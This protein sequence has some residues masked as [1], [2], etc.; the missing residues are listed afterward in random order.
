MRSSDAPRLADVAAG[1]GVSLAT[2]SRAMTGGAGVSEQLAA[3]VREVAER[4]GYVPNLHARGLAGGLIASIGLIVHEIGDPYF[5]EIASGVLKSAAAS[6]RSVQIAHAERDPASE[7][8]QVRTLMAQRLGSIIIAGSGYSDAAREAPLDDLLRTYRRRGGRVAVIGRHHLAVDAVL[9]DNLAAG[10]SLGRHLLALGHRRVGL[11][12][13]P[14]DINTVRDRVDGMR[15]V[16]EPA[17]ARIDVVSEVFAR[18]GGVAG[19]ERLLAESPDVTAIVGLNDAM[20]LGVLRVLRDRGLRVPDDISV[21]GFDDITVA[22]D[23]APALTTVRIPMTEMGSQAVALT[24][25]PENDEPRVLRSG[26]ALVVRRSTA[27]P[28]ETP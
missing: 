12:A 19:C 1:A 5:A 21:A 23:V 24:L 14:S 20:A 2:A 16:L 18:E 15:S 8:E 3:H 11:V 4:L 13:G 17:G 10:E 27:P 22:A 6:G 25:R 9:P 7:L 26:H 28:R